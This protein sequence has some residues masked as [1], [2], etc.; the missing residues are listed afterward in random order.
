MHTVSLVCIGAMQ[1]VVAS[2]EEI[3]VDDR[4][5]YDDEENNNDAN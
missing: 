1:N 5:E 3:T 2:A 4:N